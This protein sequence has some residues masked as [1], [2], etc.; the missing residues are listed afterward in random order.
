[1]QPTRLQRPALDLRRQS[2]QP[3]ILLVLERRVAAADFHEL[4][5]RQRL[6]KEGFGEST[7]ILPEYDRILTRR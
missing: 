2:A 4:V 1:M 6:F 7:P 5:V 3:S